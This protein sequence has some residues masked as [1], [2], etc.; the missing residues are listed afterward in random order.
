MVIVA[1]FCGRHVAV[2]RT[3]T[4][5]RDLPRFAPHFRLVRDTD[6]INVSPIHGVTFVETSSSS[7]HF[8]DYLTLVN[9]VLSFNESES[10]THD[11]QGET[12]AKRHQTLRR[13]TFR[14]VGITVV[15]DATTTFY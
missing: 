6:R 10:E 15:P 13:A 12:E 9:Y 8:T 5:G 14:T 1:L 11:P 3:K 7:Y 4:S 2:S